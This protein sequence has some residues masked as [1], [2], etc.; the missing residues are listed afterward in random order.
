M[1][2]DTISIRFIDKSQ[3]IETLKWPIIGLEFVEQLVYDILD[4]KSI[5]PIYR[6]LFGLKVI[7]QTIWFAPNLKIRDLLDW[8]N[9]SSDEPKLEL[10]MRFRPSSYK[11]L[12]VLDKTAF[13]I[14]F[15]QIR[16]DFIRARFNNDKRDFVLLNDAVLGLIASDLLRHSLEHGININEIL[17]RVNP[18]DF[19]PKRASKW[20]RALLFRVAEKINLQKT[21]QIGFERCDN[22]LDR[23]K[24]KFIE[25]FLSEVAQNYG[26]EVYNVVRVNNTEKSR[27]MEIRVR[28]EQTVE[29]SFCYI[30][31]RMKLNSN[32]KE[33]NDW[34]EICDIETISQGTLRKNVIQ[35]ARLNG[36]PIRFEFESRWHAESFL[37]YIDGY[38]RLMRKWNFNL[39]REV[40]S[41]ELNQLKLI[42]SHGPIGFETSRVKLSKSKRS[43]TFLVRKC[44]EIRNRYLIDTILRHK[45][46]LIIDVDWDPGNRVYKLVNYAVNKKM[47]VSVSTD[48]KEYASLKNLIDNTQIWIEDDD[49]NYPQ[50]LKY[51]LPPSEYDDYP[52]LLLSISDRKLKEFELGDE[53]KS[54]SSISE[55][56]KFIPS[57][58]IKML[59]KQFSLANSMIEVKLASLNGEQDVIVKNYIDRAHSTN[60]CEGLKFHYCPDE[61]DKSKAYV[62]SNQM[63]LA[64][65]IF[66]KHH[67]L[68]ETIG[69]DSSGS[70]LIQEFFP[71]GPLDKFLVENAKV[72]Q[73]LRLSISFQLA[74]ALLFL[75]EKKIIHGKIRC[76]NIFVKQIHP[77][78]V[79]LADPLGPF[80]KERDQAFIPPEYLNKNG[81]LCIKQFETG[82]DVWALGTT[83]WQIY[84]DG[85]RPPDGRYAN[86]LIQPSDCSDQV[87]N[88]IEGCWVI[89]KNFRASPQTLYRD[90]NDLFAWEKGVHDYFYISQDNNGGQSLVIGSPPRDFL[91]NF[92][93]TGAVGS[94]NTNG[95]ETKLRGADSNRHSDTSRSKQ[96]RAGSE[97][98][99][100]SKKT[101]RTSWKSIVNF[102][103]R[104]N[105]LAKKSG[106]NNRFN[107]LPTRR[108]FS[109][110]GGSNL[111]LFTCSTPGSE[112]TRLTDV[113]DFQSIS[114]AFDRCVWHVDSNR[115]KLGPEIGR[116]TSGVVIKG[117]LSQAD[118]EQV[119][120]VKCV[121]KDCS[122]FSL[123]KIDD[124]KREFDILKN[125]NHENIVKTLGYVEE[126]Y[127]MLIFEY[128][129]LGSLLSC[130]K[131]SHQ[132]DLHSLPL[133]K[134]AYD[135]ARG[136]EYLE[137]MRIV[138]C[139][140]AL[141]NILVKSQNEVKI[142]DFGLAQFIGSSNHYELRTERALPLKW[143]A[144][145]SLTTWIFTH[146][147]DVWSYGIVLWE[148]YSGGNS[149]QY[150]GTYADLSETL[151]HERLPM[152]IDC[153]RHM[154]ELMGRCWAY[155]PQDRDS[156]AEISKTLSGH[157]N[158]HRASL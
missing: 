13:E 93:V 117:V 111:S 65:W 109:E 42:R 113:L 48:H 34:D 54:L 8:C 83:M 49:K 2:E 69:I 91:K 32:T 92:N 28:Y 154:Y 157:H 104:S 155:E 60:H 88:L 133:Q 10:R 61:N 140:L 107:D 158:H 76:H 38:Y 122:N 57:Q 151:K 110:F 135:I 56:P 63:R 96:T 25:L 45:T 62:K 36:S 120:A 112:T 146:K 145:E 22:D 101:P 5:G 37:S 87:W 64:D 51:W 29:D 149:P 24:Q 147:S 50:Q 97:I 105:I 26:A 15:S 39:S 17:R 67:L 132:D 55:L 94:A 33:S 72:S 136:M 115:L 150:S 19:I 127:M 58:M 106:E 66:V 152:P 52:A 30:E 41:P 71:L 141:R 129:P 11:K 90:L 144:P 103:S 31:S 153:P 108:D 77:I 79:K 86:T 18:K 125:L 139:D 128:M 89:D 126:S 23:I 44:M 3:E 100:S 53:S 70:S 7:D 46:R 130:I 124:I 68:A 119:V 82:I 21:L 75:Q 40:H 85:V 14:I 73:V 47:K 143:Y 9:R 6:N 43:G 131:N 16:N 116:G 74:H 137:S 59:D 134:Y 1:I 156:F 4:N 27:P 95:S 98:G 102:R 114:D 84:N 138:H 81:E 99:L 20:Q 80:D 12:L 123:N 121:D 35:I 78:Q 148:I 142:C 118:G